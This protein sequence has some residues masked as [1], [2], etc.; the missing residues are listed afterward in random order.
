MET[1]RAFI[2]ISLPEVVC[3]TLGELTRTLAAQMPKGAVRWVK[4]D[5]MH[6]TVR[7]LGDTAVSQLPQIA[8]NLTNATQKHDPF[9]LQLSHLGCFP[10]ERRPRVIWVGMKGDTDALV[11]LKRDVDAALAPLG[12]EVEKRP[13][14]AHLTLGRVKDARKLAGLKWGADVVGAEVPVTAVKIIESQ[15][16]PSGPVYTI[17]H[18]AALVS[19]IL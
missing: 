18:E 11:K 16:R 12:W 8:T 7:F 9:S 13:F 14:R 1:I 3:S 17:R 19:T 2:A 4:P 15:L 6:L 5:R 10:N